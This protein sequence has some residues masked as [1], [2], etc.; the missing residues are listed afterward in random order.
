[1]KTPS[2][3][4]EGM[5]KRSP[6]RAPPERGLCGS[7]ARTATERLRR[8]VL[9]Q[10]GDNFGQGRAGAEDAGHTQ[11]EQFGD[12]ALGDDA[13]DKDADMSEAGVA[14]QL[15]DARHEGHVRAAK[16][17]EADPVGVLVAD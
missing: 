7:Q 9:A 3:G 14:E 11:R 13:A 17:A 10:E 4:W 15:Q 1:M 8:R 16:E 12:V 5:R 2:S 6:R